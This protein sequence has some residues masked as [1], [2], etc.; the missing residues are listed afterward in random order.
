MITP[1]GGLP[2]K[3]R[4]QARKLTWDHVH[5]QNRSYP[6]EFDSAAQLIEDFWN[7]VEEYV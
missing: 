1:N 6:Y 7:T 2:K 3:G 5:K 4:Y